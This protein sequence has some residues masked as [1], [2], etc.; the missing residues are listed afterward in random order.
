MTYTCKVHPA[1]NGA[2]ALLVEVPAESWPAQRALLDRSAEKH[3]GYLTLDVSLPHRK[4]STGWKSQN[5]H[6]FGHAAQIGKELGYDRRE[7]VYL[8]AE[9]TSDWPMREYKGRMVPASESTISVEVAS[10]AIEVAH[11]IAAENG[12]R[13]VE[14]R[15]ER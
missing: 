3:N 8:I 9:M 10:A 14:E 15:N 5:H 6:L 13:L 12:I 4:R 11:R 2:H 1:T 7:M